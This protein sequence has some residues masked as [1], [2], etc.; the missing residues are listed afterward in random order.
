MYK[1]ILLTVES[2]VM[3]RPS[4]FN[5]QQAVE[6][7]M[8]E[9]WSNGYGASSVK[10][11]SQKLG[12]TRSS[13]YNAF[14][15]REDLFLETLGIYF[16]Q[17]PDKVLALATPEMPIKELLTKLFA[18]ACRVRAADQEHRGC[19]VVNSVAELSNTDEKLGPVMRKAVLDNLARFEHLLQWAVD[20]GEIASDTDVRGKALALQN[21]L[22][23]LN[24]MCKAV[25][26]EADLWSAA[27]T[28]LLGLGLYQQGFQEE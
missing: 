11:L 14:G 19:L 12:I 9:F 26:S 25:T 27:K 1:I 3:A 15:S 17:S 28:T 20:R 21:L 16:D 23:G 13:F 2:F 8:N 7:V 4:K 24:A 5:R 6:I 10:A 22:I 18:A